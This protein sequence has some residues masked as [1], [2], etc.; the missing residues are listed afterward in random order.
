ME[1]CLYFSLRVEHSALCPP[2]FQ[3]LSWH[4]F[5][6]YL[7]AL[8]RLHELSLTRSLSPEM[9]QL[10]QASRAAAGG[11]FCG[12]GARRPSLS[13]PSTRETAA[14]AFSSPWAAARRNHFRD[15]GR[16]FAR[17]GARAGAVIKPAHLFAA[18]LLLLPEAARQLICLVHDAQ[19]LPGAPL[20]LEG[21]P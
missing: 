11:C 14:I 17:R 7:T 4:V 5:P 10:A 18:P 2:S 13:Q 9:P 6:Q 19:A 16:S 12:G 20:R 3:C 1:F 8:H 21:P 15:L